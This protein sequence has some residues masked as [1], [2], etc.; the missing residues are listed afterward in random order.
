[1]S[2]INTDMSGSSEWKRKHYNNNKGYSQD[3]GQTTTE[4]KIKQKE[5]CRYKGATLFKSKLTDQ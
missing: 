2:F 3:D 5:T 4:N 1:M